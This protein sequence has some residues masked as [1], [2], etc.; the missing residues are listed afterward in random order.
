VPP[1]REPLPLP[2]DDGRIRKP[3]QRLRAG[4]EAA[5]HV[6]RSRPQSP[7]SFRSV[8]V[9]RL[10]PGA[11]RRACRCG[12]AWWYGGMVWYLTR[13][14]RKTEAKTFARGGIGQGLRKDHIHAF[15]FPRVP[16]RSVLGRPFCFRSWAFFVSLLGGPV[17]LRGFRSG[18]ISTRPPPRPA[19]R[20]GLAF[21][22]VMYSPSAVRRAVRPSVRTGSPLPQRGRRRCA[23]ARQGQVHSYSLASQASH[24]GQPDRAR[25]P[26]G[27]VNADRQPIRG[28]PQGFLLF[29]NRRLLRPPPR[30]PRPLACYRGS[31]S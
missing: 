21:V 28:W 20:G 13:S 7:P 31:E 29:R 30:P 16:V 4:R 11:R 18:G 27:R 22:G 8:T 5:Q 19:M 12:M 9:A 14:V 25:P 10:Y 24:G 26:S 15:W 3:V 17:S 23:E 1:T 6:P 2:Q